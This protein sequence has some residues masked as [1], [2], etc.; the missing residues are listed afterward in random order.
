MRPA[1]LTDMDRKPPWGES[2]STIHLS[3]CEVFMK[4]YTEQLMEYNYW[5]NGLIVKHV[6][7]LT[8][9]QFLEQIPLF[10]AN[11]RDILSHTLFAE[12]S[13]LKRFEGI[14]MTRE[15]RR[16]FFR[17]EKYTTLQQL[18]NDWLDVELRLRAFLGKMDE[19]QIGSLFRFTVHD[20]RV[21]EYRYVDIFTQLAFHGMQH[22]SECAAIL[23]EMGH[24]PGNI[25]YIIFTQR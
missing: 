8:A 19:E 14:E 6:E 21:F 24:S 2:G 23:T 22:R 11:L 7:K 4:A 15:E 1:C 16:E 9:D 25:D 10:K 17:P 20:G 13:W 3:T 18:V 12:W 5:A